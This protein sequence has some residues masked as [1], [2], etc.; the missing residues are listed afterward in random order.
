MHENKECGCPDGKRARECRCCKGPNWEYLCGKLYESQG[1]NKSIEIV[2]GYGTS[3]T[4]DKDYT[5]FDKSISNLIPNETLQD[6]SD[7]ISTLT[8]EQKESVDYAEEM[9]LDL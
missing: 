7:R 1:K 3:K 5:N 2:W 8:E 6:L 9:I 4:A